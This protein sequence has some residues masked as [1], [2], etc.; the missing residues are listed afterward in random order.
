[1]IYRFLCSLIVIF[2]A[3]CTSQVEKPPPEQ[4]EKLPPEIVGSTTSDG[5]GVPYGDSE[6]TAI[7]YQLS[8]VS[9]DPTY[10]YT[11]SNPIRVGGGSSIEVGP[12]NER[13]YLN[14]LRGPS[15]EAIGYER[16]GSCCFFETPNGF[17]GS[18]LLDVFAIYYEGL[19][20]PILLYLN[21]YDA[22]NKLV[23]MGF[24]AR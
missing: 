7:Y 3:S 13:M 8:T 4:V 20:S 24:T 22:G 6:N 11:E 16:L 23:P 15:G 2:L 17:Q 9:D 14:G 1:V 19:D 5:K 18:G 21:M 10:G 12:Q